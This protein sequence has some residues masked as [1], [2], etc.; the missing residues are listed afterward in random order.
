MKTTTEGDKKMSTQPAKTAIITGGTKGVGR[1]IGDRFARPGMNLVI[2]I[3]IEM[4]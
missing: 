2:A 3:G 1:G 4:S